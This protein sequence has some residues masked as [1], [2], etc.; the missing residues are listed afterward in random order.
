MATCGDKLILKLYGLAL[1]ATLTASQAFAL[2]S[3]DSFMVPPS[4]LLI[5]KVE[6]R[7]DAR[8]KQN[9]RLFMN[10]T[11][12][13]YFKKARPG[14]V[15]RAE[16]YRK[17][18]STLENSD[19]NQSWRDEAALALDGKRIPKVVYLIGKEDFYQHFYQ[20]SA[21]AIAKRIAKARMYEAIRN[22][23][24]KLKDTDFNDELECNDVKSCRGFDEVVLGKKMPQAFFF[25]YPLSTK[26]NSGD[27]IFEFQG[28]GYVEVSKNLSSGRVIFGVDYVNSNNPVDPAHL[29]TDVDAGLAPPPKPAE[30]PAPDATSHG[31]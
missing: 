25:S 31:E 14:E 7:Y 22:N 8:A 16:N 5:E 29:R 2:I 1:I 21:V 30:S 6:T 28:V 17:E 26:N 4:K 13:E 10:E 9:E 15:F 19:L 23:W 11:F 12:Q 20:N 3:H 18:P 24:Q 27:Y